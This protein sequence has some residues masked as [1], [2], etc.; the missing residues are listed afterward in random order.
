MKKMVAWAALLI[1][2]ATVCA[3]AMAQTEDTIME[4]I[5]LF[6]LTVNGKHEVQVQTGD[7]ITVVFTVTRM[8]ADEEESYTMYSMQN[9]I[10]YDDLFALPMEN[11]CITQP[12]IDTQDIALRGDG[13]A[14]Y[15]NYL[16]LLDGS[17]W[18][19]EQLVGTFQLQINGENGVSEL[20]NNNF[21]VTQPDA[22]KVYPACSNDLLLYISDACT[23]RFETNGGS[24]LEDVMVNYG[25]LLAQ[26]EAPVRDGWHLRGWYKDYDLTEEWDF[27]NEPVAANM[28]LYAAWDEGD[29]EN[30]QSAVQPSETAEPAQGKR[31]CVRFETFGGEPLADLWLEEG[32]RIAEL[33]VPEREGYA[34]GGWYKD[35]QCSEAWNSDSDVA[36][37]KRVKLYASWEKD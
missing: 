21:C 13:R 10:E 36:A 31:V 26:P 2:L 22:T 3:S 25:E 34:F 28:V 29:P 18:K 27:E 24:M 17:E 16:S 4:P 19:D 33:P 37:G 32:Q 12:E 8:D 1:L 15:M 23:V 6:D 5:Y 30:T 14:F 20:K 9:E 11:A 35:A 7:V